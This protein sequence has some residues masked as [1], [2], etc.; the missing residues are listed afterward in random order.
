MDYLVRRSDRARWARLTLDPSGSPLVVLPAQAS[1][2]LAAEMVERHRVWIERHQRRLAAER[3]ALA[4]R[5]PLGSGRVLPLRGIEHR[6]A[7]VA[8]AGGRRRPRVRI[9]GASPPIIAVELS[10]GVGGR[11]RAVLERW[12]RAAARADLSAA[13]TR[14]S[15][16]MGLVAGALSVRD[17]RSRWGS[18]SRRGHLSFSWRLVLCPPEVLDYVVVHELA[19]LRW[20]GHGP[21]FWSLV[22]R[23]V[24]RADEHRRWLRRNQRALRA[25]LD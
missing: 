14:R 3:L 13:V 11:L 1:D 24:P 12:L 7:V 10:V 22:R 9:H 20:A 8:L 19:H 5:P 15:S 23:H 21:R 25:T 2:R 16:E 18:A 6:I 17:Q 4:D